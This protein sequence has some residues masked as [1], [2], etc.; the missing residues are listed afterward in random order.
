V[1]NLRTVYDLEGEAIE[2]GVSYSFRYRV[3]NVKGWS[4]FS[5]ITIVEA[6]DVP[7]Q[8]DPPTIVSSSSIALTLEFNL[9]TIDNNGSTIT[10]Y[11]LQSDA[12]FENNVFVKVATYPTGGAATHTL[13]AIDDG[14]EAGKIYSFRWLAVNAVGSSLTSQVR[15]VA[16]IDKFP[17]PTTITKVRSLGSSTSVHV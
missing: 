9:A 6:A 5:E 16:A 2:K 14:I 15:R 12:G 4:P 7:S 17:P 10:S 1:N 13:T 8:P 11:E 3:F